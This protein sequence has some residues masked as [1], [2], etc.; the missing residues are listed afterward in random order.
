MNG[1]VGFETDLFPGTKEK[2]TEGRRRPSPSQLPAQSGGSSLGLRDRHTAFLTITQRARRRGPLTRLRTAAPKS[3]APPTKEQP[4]QGS[5]HFRGRMRTGASGACAAPALSRLDL[6]RLTL[7]LL[8]LTAPPR[9]AAARYQRV[10][11]PT[12]RSVP[13]APRTAVLR[14]RGAWHYSWRWIE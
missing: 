4:S 5:R 8:L 7:L 10:V 2:R 13:R 6:R 11:P 9:P 14:A 3:L 1:L 12:E